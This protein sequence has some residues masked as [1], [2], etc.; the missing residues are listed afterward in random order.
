VNGNDGN[1]VEISPQS[2]QVAKVTLVANGAGDLLGQV[3]TAFSSP[4][5][6]RTQSISRGDVGQD[7]HSKRAQP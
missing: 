2:K 6:E 4:T 5:T 3:I 1:A 7:A